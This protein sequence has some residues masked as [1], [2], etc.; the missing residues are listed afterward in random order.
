MEMIMLIILSLLIPAICGE[1][2][3]RGANLRHQSPG[4]TLCSQ[5]IEPAGYPC[6]EHTI[7]TKDGYLLALQRVSSRNGNIRLQRGPPVLLQHGLFMAGDAWFL[8]SP[9]QSLGYILA[10]EGFDIWVGN[11]R[12]TFWS[13]GHVS[14][15]DKDKEFWDWSWQELALFDLSE[16]IQHIYS[17]ANSKVFVVGHSQGTLMSL[18]ALTQP[19]IVEMVEAAALLCP[20]SYLEHISAPFVLRMVGLHLDQMVL[21]M[22]IHQLN[23]RSK[24]LINLLDSM[25]DGLIECDDLL[26]SITG[27]NCCLD[28]SSVDKF[29]EYEPHPSSAKNLHHLFQMIRQGT[30]SQYDYGIL[31]NLKLYGQVKPPAFDLSLIPKSLPLWMGYGG[32]DALADV[33]DVEHTLKELQSKPEL[34]YLENY[35][36]LDFLISVQ[37]KKDVFKHMIRFFR[38][39]GKSSS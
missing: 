5:L 29:F 10:D 2:I 19:N 7:Q 16:M 30:F 39:L 38:S 8:D 6:T 21:A 23:F 20:I 12:G 24:V 13:Y 4:E 14:L 9:E 3:A 26:T 17:T 37:G 27:Q 31:K 35:G 1:F 22:G 11:V 28:S 32:Y 15:S 36:H 33:T 25:C 18:A 34:L